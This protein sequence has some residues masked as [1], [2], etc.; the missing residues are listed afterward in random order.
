MGYFKVLIASAWV[1]II[2]CA[3]AVLIGLSRRFGWERF[4][5]YAGIFVG[6]YIAL[7]CMCGGFSLVFRCVMT[8]NRAFR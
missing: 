7:A 1:G 3:I 8:R 2:T 4:G 6:G 5:M